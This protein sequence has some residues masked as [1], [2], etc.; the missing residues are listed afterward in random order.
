MTHVQ[1]ARQSAQYA[2]DARYLL[3]S[4]KFVT[5]NRARLIRT[6]R[7]WH[8]LACIEALTADSSATRFDVALCH[9]IARGCRRSG[10]RRLCRYWSRL[11]VA[12]RIVK[13]S[14]R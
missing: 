7:K 8:V 13:G 10:Q 9:E 1:S 12:V 4:P 5:P 2:R 6:A 11:A 14:T 3:H